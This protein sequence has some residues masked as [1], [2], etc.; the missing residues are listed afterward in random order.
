MNISINIYFIVILLLFWTSLYNKIYVVWKD[1]E[2][3]IVS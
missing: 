3:K 1:K 2:N